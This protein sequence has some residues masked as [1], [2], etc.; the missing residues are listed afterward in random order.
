MSAEIGHG[1]LGNALAKALGL[2]KNIVSFELRVA[3]GK[4]I[5]CKVELLPDDINAEDFKLAMDEY[6]ITKRNKPHAWAEI[7]GEPV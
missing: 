5:T 3:V 1:A 4:I 6:V 2:P 7:Q